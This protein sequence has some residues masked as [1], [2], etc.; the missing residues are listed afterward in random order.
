MNGMGDR[1]RGMGVPAR[2]THASSL[3][4]GSPTPI[5]RPSSFKTLITIF[6][7]SILALAPLAP[8]A[9]KLTPV[10]PPAPKLTGVD[11]LRAIAALADSAGTKGRS[12]TAKVVM[13]HHNH[14]QQI[15]TGS[16]IMACLAGVMV[17]MNN[18]NPQ[19]VNPF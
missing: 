13:H 5:P 15:I 14:R 7:V 2:T 16:V 4:D 10:A 8:A 18:Y 9:E 1:G 11:S 19:P 3:R 12:D 6:L 17:V